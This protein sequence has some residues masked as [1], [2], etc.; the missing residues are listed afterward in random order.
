MNMADTQIF[1]HAYGISVLQYCEVKPKMSKQGH[2]VSLSMKIAINMTM[3]VKS[4]ALYKVKD[5]FS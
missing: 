1:I 5:G 2:G 3:V 4:S